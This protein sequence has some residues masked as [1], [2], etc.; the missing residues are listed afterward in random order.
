MKIDKTNLILLIIGVVIYPLG[1]WGWG[2]PTNVLYR[3][4]I[5]DLMVSSGVLAWGISAVS[6]FI[7]AIRFRNYYKEVTFWIGL[8]LNYIFFIAPI[9][10]IIYALV[11][12]VTV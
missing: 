9:A 6:C 1:M 11:T 7:I 8:I 12:R 5:Q 4:D 10:F 2:I 3:L